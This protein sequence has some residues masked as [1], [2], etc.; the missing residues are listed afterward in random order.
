MAEP[1]SKISRS[2]RGHR[3]SHNALSVPA[4][5][6]CPQCDAL[7]RPHRVCTECGY[8]RDREVLSPST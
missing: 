2:R 3:R 4:T 5:G 6:K 1:T 7:V 8:Y